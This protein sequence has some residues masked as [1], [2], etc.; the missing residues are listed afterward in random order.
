MD[1]VVQPCVG[2]S[3]N[4]QTRRRNCSTLGRQTTSRWDSWWTAWNQPGC[5]AK[6]RFYW[7][8]CIRR[9][10]PSRL[11]L[12]LLLLLSQTTR[13]TNSFRSRSQSWADGRA[14]STTLQCTMEAACSDREDTPT[15]LK[16]LQ[17]AH[18][19]GHNFIQR[20]QQQLLLG[21]HC[22]KNT[23]FDSCP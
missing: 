8:S 23:H 3:S 20:Q 9:P 10:H 6:P 11:Q 19:L 14:T 2:R 12:T 15:C 1:H 7:V 16:V 22:A 18:A 13:R 21:L 5:C 17:D 4:T